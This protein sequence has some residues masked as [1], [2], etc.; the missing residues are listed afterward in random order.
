MIVVDVVFWFELV[1]LCDV[2]GIVMLFQECEGLIVV[3]KVM[4]EMFE[5]NCWVWLELLV[6]LDLQV[7]GFLVCVVVVLIEVGVLCNVI[8]VYYYDYIFVLEVCVSDVIV[9]IEVLCIDS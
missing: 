3:I 7:V 6:F 2:C 9:V 1:N 5:Y 4:K 8:V